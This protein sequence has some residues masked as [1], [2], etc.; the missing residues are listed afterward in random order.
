M[1]VSKHMLITWLSIQERPNTKEKLLQYNI[2]TDDTC[3]LCDSF[4][5]TLNHLFFS[6]YF[7]KLLMEKLMEW[8]DITWRNKNL[9][10]LISSIKRRYRGSRM[11]KQ[12]IYLTLAAVVYQVWQARNTAFWDKKVQRI[13]HLVKDIRCG[14][15]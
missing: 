5:E 3:C 8:L 9:N 12:V 15:T 2:S 4:T 7:S 13:E 6:C 11:Q 14:Y 1:S 10:Q